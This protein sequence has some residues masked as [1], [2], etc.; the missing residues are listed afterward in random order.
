[1]R[2]KILTVM[3]ILLLLGCASNTPN[4]DDEVSVDIPPQT[5][6]AVCGEL[7][8]QKDTYPTLADMQSAGA[9]LV[10]YSPCY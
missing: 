2:L 9:K 3:P 5:H 6:I 10:S 1:M 7:D 8:G 4:I